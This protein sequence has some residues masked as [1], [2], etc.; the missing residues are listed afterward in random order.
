MDVSDGLCRFWKAI[1]KANFL[2]SFVATKTSRET[3]TILG[4]RD[5]TE[6]FVVQRRQNMKHV[7]PYT[8]RPLPL[9]L[10]VIA[11]LMLS[12]ANIQADTRHYGKWKTFKTKLIDIERSKSRKGGLRALERR[13]SSLEEGAANIGDLELRISAL[14]TEVAS[15]QAGVQ[16]LDGMRKR[17]AELEVE[18]STLNIALAGVGGDAAALTTRVGNVE[19]A[20]AG[21]VSRADFNVLALRVSD[22]ESSASGGGGGSPTSIDVDCSMGDSISAALAA[23]DAARAITITLIGSCSENVTVRRDGVT[24]QGGTPPAALTGEILIEGAD[25]VVIQD[26]DIVDGM[27]TGV[28]VHVDKG[29]SVELSNLFISNHAVAGLRVSKNSFAQIANVEVNKSSGGMLAIHVSDTSDL[30]VQTGN[31][32]FTGDLV[33]ENNS[34]ADLG[35]AGIFGRIYI[36]GHSRGRIGGGT[37]SFGGVSL[38]R[39]SMFQS[40]GVGLTFSDITC[41]SMRSLVVDVNN[42]I[43]PAIINA[44]TVE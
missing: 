37:I 15:F 40:E 32:P 34:N 20:L 1:L 4:L 35:T 16:S 13:V 24:I 42:S 26:L 19:S 27:G 29:S 23:G 38:S 9:A 17:I 11:G 2:P 36:S 44:C 41:S 7:Y 5:G 10:A 6:P 22:L 28:G 25:R 12:A 33:V 14:E 8:R 18:V 39:D 31:N 3:I 21:L 30:S 43:P